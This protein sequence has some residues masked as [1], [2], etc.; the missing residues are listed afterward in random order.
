MN[1]AIETRR[2]RLHT[3]GPDFL[4]ASLDGDRR[5]AET[6]SGL[7]LPEDWPVE[8]DVLALRLG[9]LETNPLWEPWLT[10]MIELRSNKRVIGIMGFHGPPGGDWLQQL[11]PGGVEFGYTVYP[12]WRRRGFAMEASEALILWATL[13]AGVTTFALSMSPENEASAALARR[14]GFSNVGT[15]QHEVRG[16]EDVYRLD[17]GDGVPDAG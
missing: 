3:M 9:Q 5:R 11:A 4:R 14:L 12:A 15:W 10:R 8:P 17:V 6:L 1:D 13:T 16:E 2:L 7:T